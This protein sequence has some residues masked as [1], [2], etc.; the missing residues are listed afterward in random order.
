[1][2]AQVLFVAG[3]LWLDAHALVI[4]WW[5]QL[6]LLECAVAAFCVAVEDENPWLIALTP[7]FRSFYM[8]VL[9]VARLLATCEEFKGVAMGWDKIARL[10]S[11]KTASG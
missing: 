1:V 3:G 6:I 4:Y 8:V 11:F 5:L 9:D 2:A 7:V 10:G